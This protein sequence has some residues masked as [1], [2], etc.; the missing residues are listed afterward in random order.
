MHT[1]IHYQGNVTIIEP[2][3]KIVGPS[4]LAL[5][6][7]IL[8]H[9]GADADPRIIINFEHVHRMS[10][11]G[12]GMLTQARALTKRKNGRMAVIHVSKHINNLLVLS[13]LSSLFE[14]FE[15]EREAISA[16]SQPPPAD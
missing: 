16:L 6:K 14:H 9:I 3:G 11:S 7:T 1:H 15:T 13:R 4:V 12:L 2:H 5:R 10:S 8:P